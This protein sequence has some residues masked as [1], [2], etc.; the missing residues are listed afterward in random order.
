M[1]RISSISSVSTLERVNR[2]LEENPHPHR[3]SPGENR[4]FTIA[5]S[6]EAG[7]DGTGVAQELARRLNWTVYDHELVEKVASE[8]G[9]QARLVEGLDERWVGWLQ[10]AFDG[11]LAGSSVNQSAYVKHLSR[12]LLALSARGGCVIVGRGAAQILP[13]QTTLRVRLVG[14]LRE[15][16]ANLARMDKLSPAD[17][18]RRVEELDRARDQFIH[19]HFGKSP[20]DLYNYDLTLNRAHLSVPAC[21]E[22]ILAAL[23]C[24][25]QAT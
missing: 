11:L 3:L 7:T 17:A 9:L 21:A 22:V 14:P 23:R 2:Y 20:G 13:P 10:E 15:R 19:K 8:M 16:I 24:R 18:A 5:L 1:S 12:T 6:R 4:P 25:Q